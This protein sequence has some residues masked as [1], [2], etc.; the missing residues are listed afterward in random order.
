M[1]SVVVPV[2][3]PESRSFA[4]ELAPDIEAV[5]GMLQRLLIPPFMYSIHH[6]QDEN[7]SDSQ[8]YIP[9]AWTL[10]EQ[11]KSGVSTTPPYLPTRRF[12]STRKI[13]A[14][15][16]ARYSDTIFSSLSRGSLSVDVGDFLDPISRYRTP[17]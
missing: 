3:P 5:C 4:V 6:I 14:A 17:C 7:G 11:T 15:S 16:R 1:S 10:L 8:Q 13:M 12:P 2:S 9:A